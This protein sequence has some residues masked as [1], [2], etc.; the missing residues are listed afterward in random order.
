MTLD[1]A[2]RVMIEQIIDNFIDG[3]DVIDE[4]CSLILTEQGIESNLE[5]ALSFIIGTVHGVAMS[6]YII[7]Y[8]RKIKT[9]EMMDLIKLLKRRAFEVRMAVLNTRIKE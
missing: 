2:L 9:E 4:S 8:N 5:T 1:D 6:Y 7:K 3:P